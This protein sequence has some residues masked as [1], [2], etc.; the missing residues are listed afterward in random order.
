MKK[1]PIFVLCMIVFLL[2][3][4]CWDRTE[5]E[6]QGFVVGSAIDLEEENGNDNS[7]KIKLTNQIV[8][9]G[10]LGTP[11]QGGGRQ[12][13]AYHNITITG[14]SIFEI[15]REMATSA[16]ERLFFQHM[17]VVV[18]SDQVAKKPQ[19]F[20]KVMDVYIRDHEMRRGMTVLIA[21]EGTEAKE[22]LDVLPPGEKVP[23]LYIDSLLENSYKTASSLEPLQVGQLQERMLT[24]RSY[25]IPEIQ[26]GDNQTL[27]YK[28]AAVFQA[29]ENRMVASLSGEETRG[30]AFLTEHDQTSPVMVNVDDEDVVIEL[31]DI[32]HTYDVLSD[33][34]DNLAFEISLNIEGSIT[35]MLGESKVLK[36]SFF[37]K[38]EKETEKKV[39]E[40]TEKT[41][42]VVQD[43]LQVD[44]IQ[45]GDTL[46]QRH[47]DLWQKVKDNWDQ[48]ENYFSK[49]DIHVTVDVNISK[50][51]TSDNF[52]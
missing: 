24:K 21:K 37:K 10:G 8:L 36:A 4:G 43:D 9:P 50:T 2:L 16:N 45:I 27:K 12:Q 34:K 18:V 1:M 46:F 32:N 5:I 26:V 6:D 33:D 15:I 17:K 39:K 14:S 23:A 3:T 22:I 30:L 49:A 48:G 11:L 35:E 51:G 7:F 41:I 25:T 52:K 28:N 47:Y 40:I 42:K 19:L 20:S 38:L 31:V 13:E 29:P 44:V